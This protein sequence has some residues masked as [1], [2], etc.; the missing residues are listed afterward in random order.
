MLS[1]HMMTKYQIIAMCNSFLA[2]KEYKH[3]QDTKYGSR[4]LRN[5]EI[6]A[7]NFATI[8]IGLK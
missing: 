8:L 4:H 2:R 3:L 6:C 7:K 1:R 5:I